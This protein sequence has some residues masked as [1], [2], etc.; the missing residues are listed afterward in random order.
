[1]ADREVVDALCEDLKGRGLC[2]TVFTDGWGDEVICILP[3]PCERHG[4]EAT[5]IK[6]ALTR[7]DVDLLRDEATMRGFMALEDEQMHA[8]ES[9]VDRKKQAALNDL[10]DRIEEIL[11]VEAQGE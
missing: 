1:M 3:T 4:P 2:G 10:A 9:P 11:R 5:E 6:P 8:E 7:A